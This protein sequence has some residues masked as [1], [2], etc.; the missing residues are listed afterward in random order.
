MD[1]IIGLTTAVALSR[2]KENGFNEIK[3][4]KRSSIFSLILKVF[5]E[6]MILILFLIALIYLFLGEPK[7][8][9]ALGF[10]VF[11]VIGIT[12]YQE[13]KTERALEALRELGAPM[14]IVIRDGKHM[15]INSR[16]VVV[17]DLLVV[18]EGSR[19]VA[20][21]ELVTCQNI[22]CDESL[23]TGESL[24]ITKSLGSESNK[25]YSGSLMVQGAGVAKVTATSYLTEIGKIGKS[26]ET[27]E[28]SEPLLKI[29]INR[30][31]KIFGIV[32]L[33]CC[34]ILFVSYYYLTHDFLTSL[35]RGLTLS[36]S[37]LP[38]EFPVVMTIFLALGAWRISKSHVLT[39]NN[40][41]IETLGATTVL[42]VDKT[43][44][45]TSNN[46]ELVSFLPNKIKEF[47]LLTF[48]KL[49]SKR[50]AFDPLEKEINRKYLDKLIGD[51][52]LQGWHL[53][54]AYNLSKE[55]MAVTR[56]W[57]PKWA[58]DLVISAKGAP[59]TIM[60]LCKLSK[61]DTKKWMDEMV[62]LAGDGQRVLGV[63]RGVF[64]GAKFP[65]SQKDLDYE[66]LGLIGFVDPIRPSVRESME[67][68][69]KAG[70]RVIMITGDYPGTAVSIAKQA[71]ILNPTKFITGSELATL[72]IEEIGHKI[73]DINIFARIVPDQK[74]KIVEALKHRGEIV[75]M[76][77]DGINDA[78][79]L[80]SAH[81]G[82]AMGEKGTDV[83]RESADLILL[84]DD[85]SSIVDA[86]KMGR[87]IYDNLQ[88][89]IGYI[90]AI[91]IPIAGI[92]ITPLFLGLP[93]VLY[94]LHI[95]FLE[96]I[97]DP[98][99]SI[100]F[101]VEDAEAGIMDRPPRKLSLP[102]FDSTHI[103]QGVIDGSIIFG[104]SLASYIFALSNDAS[105]GA[106]RFIAFITL[107][108]C[109]LVLI[110]VK[111]SNISVFK[112]RSSS[113]NNSFWLISGITTILLFL[114]FSF[115]ASAELFHFAAVP[116][117]DLGY[118]AIIVGVCYL[119]MEFIKSIKV[120]LDHASKN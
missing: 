67:L 7:D 69:H 55:V 108:L 63:A 60:S 17:G 6:P 36:M 65:L 42:C 43:G 90:F 10:S 99:C 89:A 109:N 120:G 96:L 9:L 115:S 64:K 40:Q 74:L 100:I 75:A 78:P 76:T 32:G 70:I 2:L 88:K 13:R 73:K 20:D 38:E 22:M 39:R 8:S 25:I 84:D 1:K 37:M 26:L 81:I 77:G 117:T 119:L 53:K 11:F 34:L 113:R 21:G 71:G 92:A 82:I 51:D 105:E 94:P 18:E 102:L 91:H 56:I 33:V 48:A 95:A 59:E 5:Q 44:T 57:Q 66:F 110:K 41:S 19:I 72:S 93:P 30:I 111:L 114:I 61:S 50:S 15:R 46:M 87:R 14:A 58:K 83:A 62:T 107:V 4:T 31:V 80:K 47:E 24:P 98:A 28:G 79:A 45:L 118:V 112:A 23:L 52:Q 101:E 106:A 27:V 68:C 3:T 16:E 104:F 85:F 35:L 54:H 29:E 97:I 86:I 116:L 49:A 103:F 12:L